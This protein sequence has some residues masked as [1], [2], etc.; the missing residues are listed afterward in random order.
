MP[1]NKD[2]V[3]GIISLAFG[4]LTWFLPN[5]DKQTKII[6]AAV[7]VLLIILLFFKEKLFVL[8][9][10][11]TEI[12]AL[13]LIG[14]SFF[15]LKKSYSAV[16]VPFFMAV[17]LSVLLSILFIIKYGRTFVYRHKTFVRNVLFNEEDWQL[18]HW[19]GNYAT[20]HGEM[21]IFA[22]SV[23]DHPE[24]GS[25]IDLLEALDLGSTY[26]ISCFARSLTRTTGKFML[27]C[28]DKAKQPNGISVSTPFETPP[29][30]RKRIKL[31]F[32]ALY[33][34]SIRIHLQYRAGAGQIEVSDIKIYKL[35]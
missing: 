19:Q 25:N 12:A 33:N 2:Q 29:Q 16:I 30:K 18:N 28:H 26:E 23:E 7:V 35:T 8:R 34:N 31:T 11:Y 6:A 4:V 24:D 5:A 21:M 9:K 10:Y 32:R 13:L 17:L 22:G 1:I 14:G 20:I 27:W 3:F 15:V